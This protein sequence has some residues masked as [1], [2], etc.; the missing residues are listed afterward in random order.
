MGIEYYLFALFVFALV[1]IVL[2]L[3][4]KGR[5]RKDTLADMHYEE[6]VQKLMGIYFEAEDMMNSLKEYVTHV[7]ETIELQF[8]RLEAEEKRIETLNE[9]FLQE[10]PL[11]PAGKAVP[12]VKTETEKA[13]S[14]KAP[15]EKEK[16]AEDLSS[17]ALKLYQMGKTENEIAEELSISKGEVRFVLKLHSNS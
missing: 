15:P 10:R 2:F 6:K 17:R 9:R 4:F 13:E 3:V 16:K 11:K 5:K 7:N 1:L 8:K 12:E 14:R